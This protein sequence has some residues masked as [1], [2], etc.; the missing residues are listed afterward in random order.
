[1]GEYRFVEDVA[2]ADCAIEL[3]GRD[4]DD[5]FEEGRH[6]VAHRQRQGLMAIVV[7]GLGDR[8]R[9]IPS[10]RVHLLRGAR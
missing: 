7:D 9:E 8:P 6:A 2:I 4:L 3:T 5:L 10:V 1:V